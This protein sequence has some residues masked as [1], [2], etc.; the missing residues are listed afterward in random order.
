MDQQDLKPKQLPFR[1]P[2]ELEKDIKVI[3]DIG[4]Y[5]GS[6]K[7]KAIKDSVR[8]AAALIRKKVLSGYKNPEKVDDHKKRQKFITV[9]KQTLDL[10]LPYD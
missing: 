2:A 5:Y 6:S 8:I 9:L 10:S 7:N 3:Q 4:G 1:Y